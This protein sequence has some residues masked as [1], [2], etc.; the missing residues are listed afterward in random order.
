MKAEPLS[1]WAE[2]KANYLGTA[3]ISGFQDIVRTSDNP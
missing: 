3:F 1:A 2:G